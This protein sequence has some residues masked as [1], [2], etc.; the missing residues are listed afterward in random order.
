LI[1]SDPPASAMYPVI[2]SVPLAPS[3]AFSGVSGC[4][5]PGVTA[6]VAVAVSLLLEASVAV[7]V[8][9]TLSAVR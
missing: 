1:P 2:V 4:R 7:I 8:A 3:A 5:N 9:V 6:T